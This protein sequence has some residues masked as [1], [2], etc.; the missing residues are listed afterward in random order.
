MML[1]HKWMRKGRILYRWGD[2]PKSCLN[3]YLALV[4]HI[5]MQCKQRQTA[6]IATQ[7]RK[8]LFWEI[9]SIGKQ[10]K[11][12]HSLRKTPRINQYSLESPAISGLQVQDA[13]II[14]RLTSRTIITRIQTA[15]SSLVYSTGYLEPPSEP[16]GLDIS[17]SV[18]IRQQGSRFKSLV[19]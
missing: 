19:L 14:I 2:L 9:A 10:I 1:M 13:I 3:I 6:S 16:Y 7:T 11:A 17:V 18:L 15:L 8:M 5:A 12:R 4:R